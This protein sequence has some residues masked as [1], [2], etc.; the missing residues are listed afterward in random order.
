[1]NFHSK[2]ANDNQKQKVEGPLSR[3][4]AVRWGVTLGSQ[5]GMGL[6]SEAMDIA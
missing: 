4:E 2:I 1:M 3:D 6:L 5:M